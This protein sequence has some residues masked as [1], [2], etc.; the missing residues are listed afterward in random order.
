MKENLGTSVWFA[1]PDSP[2]GEIKFK[3]GG[4]K[5]LKIIIE[6]RSDESIYEF[7]SETEALGLLNQLIDEAIE[8][9][10]NYLDDVD[11][12]APDVPDVIQ[13][14]KELKKLDRKNILEL[15]WNTGLILGEYAE[16]EVI[17]YDLHITDLLREL[18]LNYDTSTMSKSIYVE[19]NKGLLIRIS[20]HKVPRITQDYGHRIPDVE[21]IYKDGIVSNK[22]INKYFGTNLKDQ[23]VLL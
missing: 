2:H 23:I 11:G 13:K 12:E 17:E 5:M 6:N 19:N 21:L 16:V 8:L 18:G 15:E 4:I 14:I 1:R 7:N 9:E 10:E 20:D 22:D 3:L